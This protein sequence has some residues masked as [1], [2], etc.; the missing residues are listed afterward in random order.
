M[1]LCSWLSYSLNYHFFRIPGK[2][3]H[4]NYH[5]LSL[6][7]ASSFHL[8]F[9]FLS[10]PPTFLIVSFLCSNFHLLCC[11]R[12][13]WCWKS[14]RG[15]RL[16]VWRYNFDTKP[17][18]SEP[19]HDDKCYGSTHEVSFSPFCNP[20]AIRVWKISTFYWCGSDV[21]SDDNRESSSQHYPFT[22]LH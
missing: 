17:S 19:L 14:L 13:Q 11:W 15:H 22:A 10:L 16:M 1:L 2:M 18:S 7:T 21:L 5:H 20:S 4:C 9:Q 3:L 12:W 6:Y 8:L